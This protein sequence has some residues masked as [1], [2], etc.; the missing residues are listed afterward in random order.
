[1]FLGIGVNT[2]KVMTGLIG[3]DRYRAHTVIGDEVNLASRIDVA[4]LGWIGLAIAVT[5]LQILLGALR[6]REISAECGAALTRRQA[7]RFN[8]IGQFFRRQRNNAMGDVLIDLEEDDLA[9]AAF[10][11]SL[12]QM[13]GS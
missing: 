2:G 4:S 10:V 5:F 8:L 12:R 3:S 13:L 6:W 1:M 9:R 11:G 7:M